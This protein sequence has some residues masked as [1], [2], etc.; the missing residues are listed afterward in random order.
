MTELTEEILGKTIVIIRERLLSDPESV[1]LCLFKNKNCFLRGVA[2][3]TQ[4]VGS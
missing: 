3:I 1:P 4:H 2:H